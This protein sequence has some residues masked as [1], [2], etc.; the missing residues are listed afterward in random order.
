MLMWV[1]A[2]VDGAVLGQDGDAALLLQVVGVHHALLDMLVGGEGA[3]LLQE[4]IHE[5]GLAVVH[6]GDDGD[7]AQGAGHG[8]GG[9]KNRAL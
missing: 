6:V 7:V 8:G 4:L 5:R 9:W 2:I 1:P 3:G